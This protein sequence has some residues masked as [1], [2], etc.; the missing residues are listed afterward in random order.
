LDIIAH[1]ASSITLAF[2]DKPF[3]GGDKVILIE[4]CDPYIGGGNY[5]M[6]QWEGKTV[7]QR[8]WLCAVTEFVFGYVPE[9][10]FVRRV[11]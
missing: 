10:I 1:G 4:K 8:L 9:N 11:T 3:E 2:D 7:D 6:P 5:V